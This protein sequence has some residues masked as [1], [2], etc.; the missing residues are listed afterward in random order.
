LNWVGERAEAIWAPRLASATLLLSELELASVVH[1]LRKCT[2]R[3]VALS[4]L[5]LE[6]FR[7]QELGFASRELYRFRIGHGYSSEVIRQ[8]GADNTVMLAIGSVDAVEDAAACHARCDSIGLGRVFGY[9]SCCTEFFIEIWEKRRYIDSTWPMA[10]ASLSAREIEA[11]HLMVAGPDNC[12][13][14]LK[15]LG[16]RPVFHLPCSFDCVHTAT[17]ADSLQA[18]GRSLGRHKEVQYLRDFLSLPTRWSALHGI[19]E[20]E[21]PIFRV[22]SK[23]DATRTKYVVDRGKAETE[24]DGQAQGNRFPFQVAAPKP[25]LRPV[26][27]AKIDLPQDPAAEIG[28]SYY[29]ENGFTSRFFMERSFAPIVRYL[30]DHGD[31]P[32]LYWN[33]RNGALLKQLQEKVPK[34]IVG[35]VDP[36]PVK[37][38]HAK[39]L[40]PESADRFFVHANN[41]ESA[42]ARLEG[43]GTL[44]LM[45]GRIGEMEEQFRAAFVRLALMRTGRVI[46]YAHKDWV[47]ERQFEEYVTQLGLHCHELFD[48]GG[49]VAEVRF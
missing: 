38:A 27:F 39:Q 16:V 19:A 13:M 20:I 1:G 14:L 45:I 40:L 25:S 42:L 29:A 30:V 22:S 18:L 5:G 34:M 44:V 43:T 2:L 32:L 47:R 36:D 8:A 7:F 15:S 4:Q 21:T 3:P 48:Y 49:C 10:A 23:T 31:G 46:A 41:D 28:Q 24:I 26:R 11:R 9:P 6:V 37:I 33:C 12:N 35:G 17:L